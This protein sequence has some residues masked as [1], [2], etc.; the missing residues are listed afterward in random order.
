M[1][2]A[3]LQRIAVLEAHRESDKQ[4]TD[5]LKD[6]VTAIRSDV[7]EI[8]DTVV[9]GKGFLAGASFVVAVAWTSVLAV[10]AYLWDHLVN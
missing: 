10:G 9:R 5:A 2:E 6:D 7:K 8:K 1:P 3:V 4:S